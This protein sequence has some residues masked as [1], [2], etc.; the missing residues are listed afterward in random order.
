MPK[1]KIAF[2][3]S[4]FPFDGKESFLH[5]EISELAKTCDVLIVPATSRMRENSFPRFELPVLR[6]YSPFSATTLTTAA[7]EFARQPAHAAGALCSIVAGPRSLRAKIRNVLIFPKA[8]AVA[9]LLRRAKITHVHA[10]WLSTPA[11]IAYVAARLNGVAWSAT[12]H[13]WDIADTNIR[14]IGRPSAGFVNS[15]RFV[16]TISRKG[17]DLVTAALG[18]ENEK[19]VAVI[20]LGVNLPQTPEFPAA[21]PLDNRELRLACIAGFVPVKG[22]AYLLGALA[23]VQAAGTAFHCTMF[24]AGPLRKEIDRMVLEL[25][26]SG[27]VQI[28]EQLPHAELLRRLHAHLYDAA[29]LASVDEGILRCEG[30]PVSLME[31]MAEG[32]PCIA[33]RS[34]AV[35]ELVNDQN[36]LLVDAGDVDALANAVS[37]LATDAELRHRLGRQARAYIEAEFFVGKTARQLGALIA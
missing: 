33:T 23:K 4:R 7:K 18:I 28:V 32:I 31:A 2:I 12:G 10:Y 37:K 35:P 20:H 34:G 8:L 1:P 19:K 26:L 13:R 5:A 29:I 3:T 9:G 6:Q 24:G 14:T 15:A 17:G 30:I 21:A 25:G 16:R 22:H 11:T 36:G 27:R